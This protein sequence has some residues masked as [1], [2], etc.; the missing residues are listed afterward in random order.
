LRLRAKEAIDW[1][2]KQLKQVNKMGYYKVLAIQNQDRALGYKGLYRSEPFPKA[3]KDKRFLSLWERYTQYLEPLLNMGIT[4]ELTLDELREYA[5]LATQDT[6]D[7]YE[8]VFFNES[9]ECPH[10]AEYY[11]IDVTGIGGYSIVGENFFNASNENG[12]FATLSE[13]FRVKANSNGLFNSVEDAMSFQTVLNDLNTLSPGCVEQ[14]DWR[15]LYVFK[16]S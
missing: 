15:I 8:V 10:E 9:C 13:Y 7:C 3:G 11:G 2:T 4:T 5:N 6:G 14:E 12:L 1:I 16:V